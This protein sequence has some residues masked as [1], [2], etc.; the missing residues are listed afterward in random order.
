MKIIFSA[1]VILLTV[2]AGH[3]QTLRT[4]TA[5]AVISGGFVVGITVTDGG[6]GYTN[7]PPV[8]INPTVTDG[9]GTN[10]TATASVSG[11]VVTAITINNPGSGYGAVPA[12]NIAPPVVPIPQLTVAPAANLFFTDLQT[13][14]GYHSWAGVY[15][16][17][18]NISGIWSNQEPPNVYFAST[19]TLQGTNAV[20][21]Y[22]TTV[23]GTATMGTYA[24]G[25][26]PLPVQA[27]A[28]AKVVNG[29]VTEIDVTSTGMGYNQVPTVEIVGGGGSGAQAT[30]NNKPTYSGQAPSLITL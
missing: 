19:G 28:T 17:M 5:T 11:G 8:H 15:Y 12:V 23:N 2:I 29:F 13:N 30:A 3:G 14:Y 9:G 25:L 4:A 24:L 21:N 18:K 10:A 26:F 22:S 7:V 20:Y 16:L 6:S 27:S 1:L